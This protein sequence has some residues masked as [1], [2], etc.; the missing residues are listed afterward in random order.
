MLFFVVTTILF[1]TLLVFSLRLIFKLND[2]IED[3]D[4][5]IEQSLDILDMCYQR[6]SKKASL[7]IFSD[8]PV[9]KQVINDIK[10]SRDAMLIIANIIT[11]EKG[12]KK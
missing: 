7:E 2:K 10:L 9:V 8:E 3:I 5:K 6:I 4:E 11:E 1:F 12:K